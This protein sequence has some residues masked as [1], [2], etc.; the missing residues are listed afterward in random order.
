MARTTRPPSMC[1]K[2]RA[3]DPKI[4]GLTPETN[5]AHCDEI[6]PRLAPN[7][8]QPVVT[9]SLFSF[10]HAFTRGEEHMYW[11]KSLSFLLH[12]RRSI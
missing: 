5:N 11:K 9:S 8:S 6:N 2:V 3:G 4:F 12:T 1:R 10:L 7:H